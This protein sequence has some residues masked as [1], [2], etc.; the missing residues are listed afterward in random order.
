MGPEAVLDSEEC[1]PCSQQAW[2]PGRPALGSSEKQIPFF[3]SLRD[4]F[5][6][7][8]P[9][10]F[11]GSVEGKVMPVSSFLLPVFN[12]PAHAFVLIVLTDT[13]QQSS[14]SPSH[15]SALHM[16]PTVRYKT[17]LPAPEQLLTW[18]H[19]LL[20]PTVSCVRNLMN[21]SKR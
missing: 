7:T 21:I 4:H 2:I 20:L 1:N 14:G 9:F 16:C 6:L 5:L 11:V 8:K 10:H 17:I 18:R 15:Q 13:K 12:L 3:V 19:T